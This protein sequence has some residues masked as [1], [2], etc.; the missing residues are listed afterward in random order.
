VFTVGVDL[1]A[2]PA[3]TAV[4]VIAWADGRAC[5]E[6]LAMK[7]TDEQVLEAIDGAEVAGIDA[8]F[9]WPEDFVEFLLHHRE[10]RQDPLADVDSWRPLAF[11]RTDRIV[12]ER[13][14]RTPLSVSTDRLGLTAMRAASLLAKLRQAGVPVDRAGG[15]AVV[16][17][18]PAVAL[19]QW[20]FGT[21]SY[22]GKD[23][24]PL[25]SLVRQLAHQAPGLD[26]G[27]HGELCQTSH[28]AFDAVICALIARAHAL[29]LTA[30]PGAAD[31]D[32]ARREGWIAVPTGRL[33]DLL[34]APAR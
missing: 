32:A 9:G 10:D 6:S 7:A 29:G 4:A 26:L 34:L 23:R 31:L 33:A 19:R 28:D 18:Y 15:G 3:K 12:A 5:V 21:V 17:V 13:Y 22:K 2:Q 27:P 14:G 30:P 1:A 25:S 20:G 11:R 8:P 24:S 16:E